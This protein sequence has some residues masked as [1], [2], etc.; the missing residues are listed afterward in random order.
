MIGNTILEANIPN[1][2]LGSISPG[3]ADLGFRRPTCPPPP[4]LAAVA[5]DLTLGATAYEGRVARRP[6]SLALVSKANK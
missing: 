6:G 5:S 4:P 3:P 1:N 2:K